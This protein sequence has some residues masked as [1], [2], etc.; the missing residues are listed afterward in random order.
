MLPDLLSVD[1]RFCFHSEHFQ[2]PFQISC[3]HPQY[4]AMISREMFKECS[5]SSLFGPFTSQQ[6]SSKDLKAEGSDCIINP[7]KILR[8]EYCKQKCVEQPVADSQCA[9]RS[10]TP[11][12][13][14]ICVPSYF[15]MEHYD[16]MIYRWRSMRWSFATSLNTPWNNF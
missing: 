14:R 3:T 10:Y 11:K 12:P 1:S 4:F 9:A 5:K 15:W 8:N 16:D 13:A 2:C 6:H 7:L